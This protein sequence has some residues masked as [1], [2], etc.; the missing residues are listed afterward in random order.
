[1]GGDNLIRRKNEMPSFF[2]SFDA[3]LL[4]VERE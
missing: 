3:D 4:E 2:D 1:M